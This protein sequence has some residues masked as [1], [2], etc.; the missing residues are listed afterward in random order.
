MSRLGIIHVEEVVLI[1]A[2]I[3]TTTKSFKCPYPAGRFKR[4]AGV[5][6]VLITEYKRSLSDPKN[7]LSLKE[8]SITEIREMSNRERLTAMEQLWDAICHDES[9]PDSPSW[10]RPIL[11]SRREKMN[12]PEAEYMTL[13]QLRESYR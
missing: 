6:T 3:P 10:H 11:E 9:E 7:H 4:Q 5:G 2:P 8:M 12:S 1:H 13:D